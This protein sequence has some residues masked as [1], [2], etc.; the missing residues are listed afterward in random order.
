M[1]EHAPK[2]NNTDIFPPEGRQV[3]NITE[4][5]EVDQ[6]SLASGEEDEY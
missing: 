1:E 6:D 2:L 5:D 3:P 4:D